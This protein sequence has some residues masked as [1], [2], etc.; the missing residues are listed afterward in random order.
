MSHKT[1]PIDFEKMTKDLN[2]HWEILAEPIQTVMRKY[3]IPDAH[4]KL[5]LF[6][7]GH[8]ITKEEMQKFIMTLSSQ[9]PAEEFNRLLKLTPETYLGKAATLA[10]NI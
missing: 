5:R 3:Q 4:N 8:K 6:T 10:N 7:Q 1:N 2:E 9:L